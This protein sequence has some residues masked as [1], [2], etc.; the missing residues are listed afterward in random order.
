MKS[1]SPMLRVEATRPPTFTWAL[2]PNRTP[3]G[4][5]RKTLPLAV[6]FPRML[7]GSGPVTRLRATALLLGW[8]KRTV[9][10]WAMLKPCQLITA[11]WLDWVTVRSAPRVDTL[12]APA[13]TEPPVGRASAAV[14]IAR[15]LTA[16]SRAARA[17]RR[18]PVVRANL[19]LRY[20]EPFLV[21]A[22]GELL[23]DADIR[24]TSRVGPTPGRGRWD[25]GC[26]W[27]RPRCGRRTP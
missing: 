22:D 7:E 1:A 6:R 25:R 24:R 27:R 11:F 20:M 14:T 19:G 13:A 5:T 21:S 8:A 16:Q 23:A 3:F 12:A 2:G 10:P 18:R 15:L 9:S 4:L 17:N 26:P